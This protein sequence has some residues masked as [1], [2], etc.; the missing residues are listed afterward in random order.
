MRRVR[1]LEIRPG[2]AGALQ[3]QG[4]DERAIA[5]PDQPSRLPTGREVKDVIALLERF[6]LEVVNDGL[7]GRWHATLGTRE[8]GERVAVA[9]PSNTG[10]T[11]PQQ[12]Y[13]DY[14]SHD[15][16]LGVLVELT[17][18]TGPLVLVPDVGDDLQ[19]IS[20]PDW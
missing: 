7:G 1:E 16:A 15:L 18:Q 19:V 11:A 5:Y 2:G 4:L 20:P 14:G 9:I 8:T 17:K 3:A 6:G 12:V 13:V 10:D